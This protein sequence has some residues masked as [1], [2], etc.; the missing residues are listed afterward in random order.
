MG[1]KSIDTQIT[2]KTGK[3]D[4]PRGTSLERILEGVV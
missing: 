1:L 2:K 4:L 3:E